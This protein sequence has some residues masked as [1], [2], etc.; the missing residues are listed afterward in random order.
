MLSGT[1]LDYLTSTMGVAKPIC[2]SA[3]EVLN[4]DASSRISETQF[5][6]LSHLIQRFN[7]G[8][9]LPTVL[10]DRIAKSI[11]QNSGIIVGNNENR[12]ASDYQTAPAVEMIRSAPTTEVVK[13]TLDYLKASESAVE[14]L[15]TATQIPKVPAEK[16]SPPKTSSSHLAAKTN[17]Q[18]STPLPSASIESNTPNV[19]G[20]GTQQEI[21]ILQTR[22]QQ[23]AV[24][25]TA[26]IA[27]LESALMTLKSMK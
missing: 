10:P 14:V 23:A 18:Q 5:I 1:A 13:N 17:A 21:S 9:P 22:L 24:E 15:K 12:I 3:W 27:Q 8:F 4:P 16:S 6:L 2:Q 7:Q 11:M 19:D 25:M 26:H 20:N